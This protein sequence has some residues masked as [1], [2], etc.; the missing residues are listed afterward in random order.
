MQSGSGAKGLGVML[1]QG[2]HWWR[3]TLLVTSAAFVV[4]IGPSRIY[5]GDHWASDVI[6]RLPDRWG[7]VGPRRG[8]LSSAQRARC[9][10]DAEGTRTHEGKEVLE[11]ISDEALVL[12][13]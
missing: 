1:F 12:N 6:G 8:S 13:S 9:A 4:L 10:A 5:L 3:T 7:L 2:R 11:I